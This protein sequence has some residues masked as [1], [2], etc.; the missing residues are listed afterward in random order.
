[1]LRKRL[2]CS[3]CGRSDSEV[4]KLAAG[5]MRMFGRVYICDRCA[6]QTIEIMETQVGG[7]PPG[8]DHQ[9]VLWRML[10]RIGWERPHDLPKAPECHAV[11]L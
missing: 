8:G 3:F 2:C 9:S 7:E 4:A 11:F 5:P 1:M 10:N 6:A